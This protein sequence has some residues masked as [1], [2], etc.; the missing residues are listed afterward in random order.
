MKH[1]NNYFIDTHQDISFYYF[2]GG[3]GLNFE[4]K[5]FAE[6]LEN[7]HA[8]IPKLTQSNTKVIFSAIFPLQLTV[9]P[10]SEKYLSDGYGANM[11]A[12]TS[13]NPFSIAM[14]HVKIYHNLVKKHCKSLKMI[15]NKSDI[16]SIFNQNRVGILMS[17]EG[18][19]ALEDHSDLELFY[20]LGLRSIQLTWNFDT[21]YAASCMSKKDYGIT[22]EG[23]ILIEEANRMGVILDIAHASKK[24]AMTILNVSKLPVIVSHGNIYSVKNHVRNIDDEVIENIHQNKGTI[25]F[26]FIGPAISE[27][28]NIESFAKHIL[29]VYN[30]YG[31]DNLALGTDYFGLMSIKEPEGLE[32]I[33]KIEKLW[34]YLLQEGF[35]ESDLEK[36]KYKN[37]LRVIQSNGLKWPD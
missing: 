12:F 10:H 1:M 9:L 30:H 15:Q 20:K 11:P 36:I 13:R 4:I 28:P 22:G 21:K 34:Q 23:E 6:D 7:R 18:S 3:A 29:Y 17:M 5:D 25:G 8:D 31:P 24:S 26:T 37:A 32:N 19:E 14:E 35:S 16:H 27:K 33:T 2:T